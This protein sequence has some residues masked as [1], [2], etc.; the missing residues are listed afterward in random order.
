[1]PSGCRYWSGGWV[2]SWL[3]P[4]R[5]PSP[6]PVAGPV[7]EARFTLS[8]SAAAAP[9]AGASAGTASA[10]TVPAATAKR[11]TLV[12]TLIESS[13][14]PAPPGSGRW[15]P[16]GPAGAG[17]PDE[18]AGT[19]AAGATERA[20]GCRELAGTGRRLVPSSQPH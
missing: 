5:N 7:T 11:P 1:M 15:R 14:E 17:E 2:P 6:T 18:P 20:S 12:L 9:W 19:A 10:S 3:T 4:Y 8:D 13:S 16:D